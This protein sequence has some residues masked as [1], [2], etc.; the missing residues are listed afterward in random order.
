MDAGTE[1]NVAD[2]AIR[3]RSGGVQL[4]MSAALAICFAGV[5]ILFLVLGVT[6]SRNGSPKRALAPMQAELH[7]M[8]K[9]AWFEAHDVPSGFDTWGRP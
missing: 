4:Y 7:R 2:T 6:S 9:S 5:G 8:G 3:Y 1:T